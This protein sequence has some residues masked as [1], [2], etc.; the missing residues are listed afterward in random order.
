MALRFRRSVK[1]APGLR[2]NFS[3]SGL[4]LTAGPRGASVNF[5]SRGTYFNSGIPG[6]GLYSRSRLSGSS[7]GSS[8]A[9]SSAPQEV[10][11][12]AKVVIDDDTGE[13]KY[14]YDDG[15]PL[16]DEI[17][18]KAKRQNGELIHATIEKAVEKMNAAANGLAEI[19]LTT[20]APTDRIRY[21]PRSFPETAPSKPVPEVPGFLARIFKSLAK[22]VEIKNAVAEELYQKKLADWNK[23]KGDFD[24]AEDERRDFLERRVL[25]EPAAMEQH[26]ESA[27]ADIAWPRETMT[28]FEIRDEG[29]LVVMDVDL[30]EVED[31]PRKVWS[32]QGRYGIKSKNLS[33]ARVQRAYAAHVHGVGFRIA[34]EVFA[35]LPTVQTLVLSAYSQRPDVTTGAISD[36]YLY[37][38]R[39]TREAWSKINFQNLGALDIVEALGQ[40]E[41][42]RDMLKSGRF[43]AIEPLAA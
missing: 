12:A 38:V 27:L 15:R 10:M 16:P 1:L 6:T 21:Q 8:S 31:M 13:I 18:A 37:S 24:A 42:R 40:F 39:I 9:R 19:H 25:S 43:K 32:V 4:S 5:G 36:E 23:G 26:L 29:S 35:V 3:G 2:L 17:I 22:K 20:P 34:G 28:S 11:V 41:L 30:P 7:S 14:T 33:D